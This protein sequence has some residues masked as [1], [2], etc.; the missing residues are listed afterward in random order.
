[1][2]PPRRDHDFDALFAATAK[3]VAAVGYQLTGDHGMA[4]EALQETFAAVHRNMHRFRGESAIETWVFRI[5]VNEAKRALRKRRRNL[6]VPPPNR[7]SLGA[8][9]SAPVRDKSDLKQA[10][11]AALDQLP[12]PQRDVLSLLTIRGLS[13]EVVASVLGVPEGTVYS[14][15]YAARKRL[16]AI[17]GDDYFD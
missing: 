10:L 9:A 1:M 2:N 6:R 13:G 4:E 11:Y 5:A 14:R 15:A 12:E 3:R 8:D 17:L 16:R 7:G